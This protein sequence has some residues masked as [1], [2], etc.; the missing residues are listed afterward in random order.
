MTDGAR[1]ATLCKPEVMNESRI[2]ELRQERGWT[3]DKL[4]AESGVGIRT[5]QRLEA[6]NDAS[7]ETLSL[8]AEAL[9]VTVRELF[10]AIDSDELSGRVDS[11]EVRMKE[12]Q[13]RRERLTTAWLWL[14]IGIGVTV[15]LMGFTIG[16][17]L[18]A[19]L[20]LSYWGGGTLIF[21]ALRRLYL[22]PHLDEKFPLSRNK[23]QLRAQKRQ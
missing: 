8:V 7:L 19:L 23:T 5:I 20:F 14:F 22:E 9:R 1:V 2:V 18:G 10:T 13:S 12:Q 17:Q 4:A 16:G 21:V 6:G 15:S 11:L 3:Q